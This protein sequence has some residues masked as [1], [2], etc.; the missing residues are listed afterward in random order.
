MTLIDK[1]ELQ[2]ILEHGLLNGYWSIEQY[3]KTAR[4]HTYPSVEFLHANPQFRVIN[5][6]D[7]DAFASVAR[8]GQDYFRGRYF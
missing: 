7:T 1:T 8:L 3:N 6:R 5:F 4:T 2:K